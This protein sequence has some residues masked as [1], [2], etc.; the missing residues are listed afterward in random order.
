MLIFCRSAVDVCV[1]NKSNFL[2][3]EV[4]MSFVYNARW[5]I[6]WY[7]LLGFLRGCWTFH[8]GAKRYVK[9]CPEIQRVRE[10]TLLRSKGYVRFHSEIKG[11]VTFRS[12]I[13]GYMMLHSWD[14]MVL[15]ASLWVQRRMYST[16][17]KA[18]KFTTVWLEVNG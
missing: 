17:E 12:E 2:V 10:V 6:V 18:R 15:E 13:E 3:G 1:C 8:S 11:C 5:H 7:R 9:S 14:P 4:F 16:F